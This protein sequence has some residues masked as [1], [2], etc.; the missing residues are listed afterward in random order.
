MLDAQ[1]PIKE[2][3][4]WGPPA[5]IAFDADGNPSKA[6]EALQRKMV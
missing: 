1:T 5:K 2:V 3:T 4:V 6:A